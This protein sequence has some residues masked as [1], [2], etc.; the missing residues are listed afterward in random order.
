MYPLVFDNKLERS[1]IPN[2]THDLFAKDLNSFFDNIDK[3]I[4]HDYE[5]YS[6]LLRK[7]P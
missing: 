5:K 7:K 3:A 1:I 4:N 2:I 6:L